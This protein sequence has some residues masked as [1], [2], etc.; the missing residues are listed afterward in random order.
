MIKKFNN[1]KLN[2]EINLDK[3]ITNFFIKELE[4]SLKRFK[5]KW[6]N[7]KALD[8]LV[9]IKF[10]VDGYGINASNLKKFANTLD[11]IS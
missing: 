2:E 4:E 5:E 1:L 10:L 9:D 7:E 11:K 6:P 8:C 3:E